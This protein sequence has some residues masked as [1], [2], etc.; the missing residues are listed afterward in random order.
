MRLDD[1]ERTAALVVVGSCLGL[2]GAIVV[3]GAYHPPPPPPPRTDI[4]GLLLGIASTLSPSSTPSAEPSVI[5]APPSTL[6]PSAVASPPPSAAAPAATSRAARPGR[7]AQPTGPVR[8]K[9]G[10]PGASD[11]VDPWASHE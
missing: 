2:F 9:P 1:P 11:V 4:V 6:A 8:R 5:A 7:R 3:W 10:A